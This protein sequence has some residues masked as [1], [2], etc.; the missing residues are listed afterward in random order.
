MAAA[1][2]IIKDERGENR[3]KKYAGTAAADDE[4]GE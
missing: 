3:F 1:F 4:S 2:N